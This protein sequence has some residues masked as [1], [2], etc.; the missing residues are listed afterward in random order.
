MA[1]GMSSDGDRWSLVHLLAEPTRRRVYESVRAARE[2]MTRDDVAASVGVAR[3]LAAFHLDLLADAGLLTVSYAR[4]PGRSGP[5][6]GRPSKRYGVADVDLE[7]SVPARRYDIPARILARAIEESSP[8]DVR[9]AS[10]SVAY[11]EGERIGRM[12]RPAKR[13]TINDSM[14]AAND[15]LDDLGYEP[16]QA[17]ASCIKLRNCPFHAVVDVAP[18]LVCRLNESFLSGLLSGVGAHRSVAAKL[19]GETPPDC[20]V[21]IARR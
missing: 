18:Q 4:P 15:V 17:D 12:R 16:E 13:M 10:T 3:R 20:C 2:P 6:A 7:V 5:G 19:D 21:T 14:V 9:A 1:A 11:D 8:G